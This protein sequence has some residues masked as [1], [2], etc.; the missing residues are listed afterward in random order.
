MQQ[1]AAMEVGIGV[2]DLDRML[3]F[4]TEALGCRETRRADIPA[5]LSSGLGLAPD[6]YL[7][8]WLETPFGEVIKLMRPPEAP[9]RR[10]PAAHL[11]SETGIAYLTFYV[12]DVASVLAAAEAGGA[13]LRSERALIEGAP[14]MPVKL[15]F[16][17]DP[18][19]N[20]IEL[21]EV[22]S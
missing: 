8:V 20:V 16:L 13:A 3:E 4:Y 9:T 15:G 14:G 1:T 7:C 5:A 12:D 10:E 22:A 11:T 6:G 19:G 2:V 18:E 17:S 21:V